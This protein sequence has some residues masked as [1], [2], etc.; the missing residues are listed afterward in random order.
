[1]ESPEILRDCTMMNL[2]NSDQ[3]K[4]V[5]ASYTEEFTSFSEFVLV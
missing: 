3:T 2:P 5:T 4:L 1:M